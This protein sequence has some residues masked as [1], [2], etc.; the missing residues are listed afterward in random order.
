[1]VRV[2]LVANHLCFREALA[3]LL[4]REPG[5]A[6]VTQAGS[7]AEA[8]ALL[9]A[10]LRAD[11]AV[12]DLGLADGDGVELVRA[13]RAR[14][15]T[16]PVIALA[17]GD[18]PTARDRALTAGAAVPPTSAPLAALLAAVRRLCA[19]GGGRGPG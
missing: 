16:I 6:A 17:D 14:E 7:L 10:G 9:A 8:R 4:G 15:P 2:L 13:R 12:A 3:I 11:V 1:M 5:V 18:E 19:E